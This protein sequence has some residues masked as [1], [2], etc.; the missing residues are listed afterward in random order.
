MGCSRAMCASVTQGE[1]WISAIS[2]SRTA[3]MRTMAA[4]KSQLPRVPLRA[5]RVL[6]RL[7][8]SSAT[9]PTKKEGGDV[10][11]FLSLCAR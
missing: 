7:A 5:A 9:L 10:H 1:R 6:L 4:T 8:T 11:P 3:R 2:H